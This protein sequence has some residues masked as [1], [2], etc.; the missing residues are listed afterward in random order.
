MIPAPEVHSTNAL[1]FSS[2]TVSPRLIQRSQRLLHP[3]RCPEAIPSRHGARPH[4]V[5]R[6]K[7]QIGCDDRSVCAHKSWMTSRPASQARRWPA[8]KRPVFQNGC[9]FWKRLLH[10][11][12]LHRLHVSDQ[13]FEPLELKLEPLIPAGL[14][15]VKNQHLHSSLSCLVDPSARHASPRRTSQ[16]HLAVED[17]MHAPVPCDANWADFVWARR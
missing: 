5:G 11:P 1:S 16:N 8:R 17:C 14:I 10:S 7:L 3:P 15:P 4:L 13:R 6:K 12:L 2:T 9:S